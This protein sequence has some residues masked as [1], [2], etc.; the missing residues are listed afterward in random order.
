[1]HFV[2]LSNGK[3]PVKGEWQI[4]D[5]PEVIATWTGNKGLLTGTVNGIV[6]VDYDGPEGLELAR[7]EFRRE[8]FRCLIRTPNGLHVYTRMPNFPVP[9]A[10]KVQGKPKDL[11][12]DGG[13]VLAAGS[14]VRGKVYEYLKGYEL[15]SVED[16]PVFPEYWLPPKKEVHVQAIDDNDP[17][18]RITRARAWLAQAEPAVMGQNGSKKF[19]FCCCRM[20]QMFELSMDQA[21]ALIHE[22]NARCVPPF[23]VKELL[24]KVEDA[25]KAAKK[26]Q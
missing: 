24:H 6:A 11:R 22:Y 7:Q 10:V 25:A 15:R 17:F 19:F 2:K 9:N 4:S 13:Y 16:L 8:L 20:F 12:S 18:H 26:G 5:D 14:K 23:S 1:M 3:K 21:Y